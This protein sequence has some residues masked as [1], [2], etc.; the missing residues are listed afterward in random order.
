ML[1]SLAALSAWQRARQHSINSKT[2]LPVRLPWPA[3][4]NSSTYRT[5]MNNVSGRRGASAS[6]GAGAPAAPL[7]QGLACLSMTP[8]RQTSKVRPPPG[9]A[10]EGFL[11]MR[12]ACTALPFFLSKTHQAQMMFGLPSPHWCYVQH[13]RAGM[14]LFLFNFQTKASWHGCIQTCCVVVGQRSTSQRP[15][16]RCSCFC[17]Q[18]ARDSLRARPAAPRAPQELHGIF[19]AA[20]DGAWEIDEYGAHAATP[21]CCYS[22]FTFRSRAAG[23]HCS[24]RSTAERLLGP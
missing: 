22:S 24:C 23:R 14:P 18:P 8:S 11:L 3:V 6:A 2:Y 10:A 15:K 12:P 19:K 21:R 9:S 17:F 5:C 4:C 13:I 16:T 20:C 1:Q 7:L